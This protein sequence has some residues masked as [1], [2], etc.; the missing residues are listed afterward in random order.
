MTTAE[1]SRFLFSPLTLVLYLGSALLYL[2]AMA[3]PRL[4]A[5]DGKH[6]GSGS[7]SLRWATGLAV[8]GVVAHLAHVVTRIE[9]SGRLPLGNM[10]EFSSII[11]LTTVL[12]GLLV[13]QWRM[14][15]PELMGFVMLGAEVT[16]VLSLLLYSDPAPLQPILDTYWRAIHV[17]TIV[18]SFGIFTLAAVFNALHLLRDTAESRVADRAGDAFGASTVG[19]AQAPPTDDEPDADADPT[20]DSVLSRVEADV[21]DIDDDD[22]DAAYRAALRD[23]LTE[24]WFG[25]QLPW[26]IMLGSVAV[27][28][29]FSLIWWDVQVSVT[30]AATMAVLA[31]VAWW[32]VPYLP[33]ATTL[34]SLTY[35]T[36][37]FSFPLW[38]FAVIT[39]AMWAEQSWGRFWGWDPKETSS[40]LTWVAYAGYLHARATRGVKG[41]K[42][43]WL[44]LLAYGV[45]LFTYYAVNLLVV[46]LHSYGGIDQ[47][48]G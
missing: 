18:V 43:S 35:R 41:R 38:T 17:S 6:D 8:L 29:V 26:R 46:G 5:V 2:R 36:I 27:G 9:A 24:Q 7:A 15:R 1:L 14:R 48:V 4:D 32:A 3:A 12:G 20:L 22:Q 33:S 39:G 34:D 44:G 28:V 45:L 30:T 11:A 19:A 40:F 25:V 23:V 10:F 42:A 31:L 37:A 21:V 47:T 16:L 13:I